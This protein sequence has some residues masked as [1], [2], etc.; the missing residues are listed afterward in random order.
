M[1]DYPRLSLDDTLDFHCGKGV[2]CFT[3]CCRD[4]SIVLTP[5]DVLRM[6]KVL[7]LD[8]T[9]FLEKYTV[10]GCTKDQKLPVVLLK[11]NAED[12]RC[13]LVTDEG[14]SIYAHRPWACRMYPLGL[15]E[16]KRPHPTEHGFYFVI[17]EDICHGH[18]K[19]SECTIRDW[20][21][22]QSI[23]TF[24]MMGEPF[25]NLML[26]EF[27]EKGEPLQPAKLEMYLMACYDLDRFRRFVFETRFTGLFDI[28]EAR[29]EAIRTDDE[30]L[31][32]FAMEWL[33]FSLFNEKTMK[34]KPS[35]MDSMER[36]AGSGSV[37]NEMPR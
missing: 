27:W 7:H 14:C 30:E 8:S 16:P 20:I 23:D 18:G 35:V 31:L 3:N 33:R 21:A 22:G 5:Y 10:L 4:V 29:L 9:E 37:A 15:A 11:M 34:L 28:D 6:K 36:V 2:D 25:K 17:H 1:R 19:G 24:E 26:N 12:K 32:V 13:P